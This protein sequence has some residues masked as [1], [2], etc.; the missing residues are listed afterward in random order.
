MQK[1]DTLFLT[2]EQFTLLRRIAECGLLGA[3]V[4]NCENDLDALRMLGFVKRH[5]TGWRVTEQGLHHM[6]PKN[7]LSVA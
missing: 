1:H 6:I 4:M 5:G 2:F 3:N 7:V